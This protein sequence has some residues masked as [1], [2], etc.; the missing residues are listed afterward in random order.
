MVTPNTKGVHSKTRHR[1]TERLETRISPKQK[2]LFKRA[3]A[4]QGR[5][6]TDFVLASLHEAATRT[7]QEY[8]IMT[9]GVRDREAFVAALLEPPEPEGRLKAAYRRYQDRMG[10]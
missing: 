6:L 1:R 2:E 7:V 4:L 3:A 5:T 10:K 8:E 9:L